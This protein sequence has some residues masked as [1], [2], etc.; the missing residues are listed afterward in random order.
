MSE[1]KPQWSQ[2]QRQLAFLAASKVIKGDVQKDVPPLFEGE[3]M[4]FLTDG[5]IRQISDAVLDAVEPP[6]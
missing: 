5:I 2:Q 3:A 6:K 4:T 1:S